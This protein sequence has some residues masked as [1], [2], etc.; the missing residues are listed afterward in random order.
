MSS[1][2]DPVNLRNGVPAS[3]EGST[4]ATQ[5]STGGF[6]SANLRYQCN[7][8]A[9]ALVVL[10]DPAHKTT[11]ECKMHIVQYIRLHL[12][13]WLAFAND[14]LG[15]GLEEKDIIFVSGFTK[16][17]SSASAELVV[18]GGV[19]SASGEFRVSLSQSRDTCVQSRIGPASRKAAWGGE[20]DPVEK[21]D[22][23][24]FLNYYK[25]KSRN[26]DD[27]DDDAPE[28]SSSS[29]DDEDIDDVGEKHQAD[30]SDLQEYEPVNFVLDYILKHSDAE[31][32]CASDAE[33]T[34]L[35]QNQTLPNDLGAALESLS[36]TIFVDEGGTGR[37]QAS[38]DVG[39]EIAM[40]APPFQGSSLECNQ[41]HGECVTFD[42]LLWREPLAADAHLDSDDSR[43]ESTA[44]FPNPVH[45]GMQ[46]PS[47][48]GRSKTFSNVP[49]RR[50]LLIGIGYGG[51]EQR[52]VLDKYGYQKENITITL[53]NDSSATASLRP[54]RVNISKEIENLVQFARPGSELVFYCEA[55]VP[56]RLTPEADAPIRFW[57]WLSE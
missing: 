36:P 45:A 18:S 17:N 39:K 11:M 31:T 50:A 24:I 37:I 1:A 53:D 6:A 46:S 2:T 41:R 57:T 30:I 10:K 49:S 54:T 20:S 8:A 28:T 40:A 51:G 4:L 33:L 48:Q 14:E 9:G 16:T 27:D 7:E 5:C 21:C 52:L 29:S 23:C 19:P 12:S 35:F 13:S 44:D 34:C 55:S 47:C 32:A 38:P 56:S 43:R 3:F 22:Q 26:H 42:D 25:S 15:L